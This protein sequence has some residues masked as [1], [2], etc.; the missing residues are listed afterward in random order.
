MGDFILKVGEGRTNV[1]GGLE[2]LI[3]NPQQVFS[4][5]QVNFFLLWGICYF[6]QKE[7]QMLLVEAITDHL[8][9]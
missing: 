4:H 3:H 9:L 2:V 6:S 5:K 1:A 7:E 8:Q